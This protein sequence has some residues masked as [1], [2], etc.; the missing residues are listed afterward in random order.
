[1]EFILSIFRRI[2]F[3]GIVILLVLERKITLIY[4]VI[5]YIIVL[6]LSYLYYYFLYKKYPNL[7]YPF[8]SRIWRVD[9]CDPIFNHSQK[10]YLIGSRLGGLWDHRNQKHSSFKE[11][12]K[13]FFVRITVYLIILII[14]YA[15]VYV[16]AK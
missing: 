3:I 6:I 1:M 5:T 2:L 10:N 11:T 13:S 7:K 16:F 15:I 9:I 4:F 8:I 14:I 12:I